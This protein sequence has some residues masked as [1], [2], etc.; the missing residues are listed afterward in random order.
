MTI[1]TYA[2]LHTN[3]ILFYK[4]DDFTKNQ[5]LFCG[6]AIWSQN[7]HYIMNKYNYFEQEAK[8]NSI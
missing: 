7:K 3:V 8:K 5:S 1:C 6:K 4:N 2:Y